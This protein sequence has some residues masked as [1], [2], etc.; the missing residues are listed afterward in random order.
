MRRLAGPTRKTVKLSDTLHRELAGYVLAAGAASVSVMALASPS[1][2]QIVYT[3]AH[4]QIERNGTMLID[5]NHD[6][7]TD[8]TIREIPWTAFGDGRYP[9]NSVQAVIHNG[10]GILISVEPKWA[11]ALGRGARIESSSPARS[12][13]AIMDQ[14]TSYGTYYGGL[15]SAFTTNRFLG[16]SFRIGQETHFGWARLSLRLGPPKK[17]IAATLTG[18]AYE[19]QPGKPIRAG[20]TGADANGNDDPGPSSEIFSSPG[21]E[22]KATPVSLGT[23]ALGALARTGSRRNAGDV[24]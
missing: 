18:Y 9:G 2:G 12:G 5:L 23:L 15:W 7:T 19:T 14:E 22:D 1:E 11:A 3:P 10:G 21:T 24:R 20:D 4:E 17:G 13:A 6:G 16:I 8:L